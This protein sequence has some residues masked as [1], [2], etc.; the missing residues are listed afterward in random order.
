MV[1]KKKRITAYVK[2]ETY[3][4]FEHIMKILK[5]EDSKHGESESACVN[6]LVSLGIERYM[7]DKKKFINK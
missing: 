3:E 4:K 6:Y 1:N 2:V 7:E 5:Q